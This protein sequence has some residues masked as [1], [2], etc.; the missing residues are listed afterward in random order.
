[1][2]SCGALLRQFALKAVELLLILHWA[3]PSLQ[4][5]Q[6][7]TQPGN[8]T[9]I[10]EPAEIGIY[11]GTLPRALA[12]VQAFEA[13][14]PNAQRDVWSSTGKVAW[15]KPAGHAE[16]LPPFVAGPTIRA[17]P[18]VAALAH[19]FQARGPPIV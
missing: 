15:L 19:A 3:A 17:T 5:V 18:G 16:T 4:P 13:G 6:P 2:I 11:R 8:A 10:Y 1:M 7:I 14:I 12:R 9:P